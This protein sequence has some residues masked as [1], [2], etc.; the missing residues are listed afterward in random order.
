MVPLKSSLGVTLA[1]KKRMWWLVFGTCCACVLM[2]VRYVENQTMVRGVSIDRAMI[3][4]VAHRCHMMNAWMRTAYVHANMCKLPQRCSNENVLRHMLHKG[5]CHCRAVR[6]VKCTIINT[7]IQLSSAGLRCGQLA[8]CGPSRIMAAS[9]Q[10]EAPEDV[11]AW[12]CT[13]SICT[14][15]RNTHIIVPASCLTITSGADNLS[16]YRFHTGTARHIFCRT[17]GVTPFYRPRSNPDGYA[18][19]L[20]AVDPGTLRSVTI[21]CFDGEHWEAFAATEGLP[22]LQ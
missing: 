13:C 5:G 1:N 8:S 7:C 20:Y 15:K 18:V 14:L 9:T 12:D 11:E 3:T 19:T 17:C 6:C 16:E 21:R 4:S 2:N 22:T 10:F